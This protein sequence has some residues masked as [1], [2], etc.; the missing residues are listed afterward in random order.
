MVVIWKPPI[1]Y[2]VS[3]AGSELSLFFPARRLV[4]RLAA[5]FPQLPPPQITAKKNWRQP[6][7][8][9]THGV[10]R[11]KDQ[12]PG[13]QSRAGRRAVGLFFFLPQRFL[14]KTRDAGN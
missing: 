5:F 2:R 1:C 3:Q 10:W 9:R 8:D 13:L 4:W 11:D 7:Q 14:W 12:R 6:Q